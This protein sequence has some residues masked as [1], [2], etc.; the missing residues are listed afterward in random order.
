MSKIIYQLIFADVIFTILSLLTHLFLTNYIDVALYGIFNLLTTGFSALST[1]LAYG[2]SCNISMRIAQQKQ[3]IKESIDNE[4]VK[5]ALSPIILLFIISLIISS[6]ISIIYFMFFN[7]G[8]ISSIYEILLFILVICIISVHIMFSAIANGSFNFKILAISRILAGIF[9][10]VFIFYFI[11]ISI[12]IS[13]FLIP[14]ILFHLISIFYIIYKLRYRIK[15][16]PLIIEFKY[17]FKSLPISISAIISFSLSNLYIYAV[18]FVYIDN[19]VVGFYALG[20]FLGNF[21]RFFLKSLNEYLIPIS[22]IEY[23]K[24]KSDSI[25]IINI[26]SI[27][28]Q[29]LFF[30]AIFGVIFSDL[31]ILILFPEDYLKA[32]LIIILLILS[33]CLFMILE[34]LNT[35]IITSNKSY[36]ATLIYLFTLFLFFSL[37][38]IYYPI[39]L[40]EGIALILIFSLLISIIILSIICLI[41]NRFML[42]V[43]KKIFPTLIISIIIIFIRFNFISLYGTD[44]FLIFFIYS[45]FFTAYNFNY[46]KKEIRR[47]KNKFSKK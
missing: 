6:C 44:V 47:L 34:L 14:F 2:Y 29:F 13:N 35:L 9:K 11:S 26:Y 40:I 18:K 39:D 17:Y 4:D 10:I 42:N 25:N 32:S 16:T 21:P 36:Y 24:E 8:T 23:L 45:I 46:L 31:F 19:T 33:G 20:I 28:F 5:I 27:L 1:F 30:I 38:F 7:I 12:S 3:K 15:K 22:R 37:L 41:R 43:Y